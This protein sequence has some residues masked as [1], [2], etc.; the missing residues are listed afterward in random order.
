MRWR[1]AVALKR[2]AFDLRDQIKAR[3]ALRSSRAPRVSKSCAA[4]FWRIALGAALVAGAAWYWQSGHERGAEFLWAEPMDAA[5]DSSGFG[6][7]SAID[8]DATGRGYLLSDRGTLF[9]A[10]FGERGALQIDGARV[11]SD[12]QGKA[13]PR[14]KLDSEG[15]AILPDGRLAVSFEWRH[16]IEIFDVD[17]RSSAML[18]VP[19]AFAD[20]GSNAGLET[21]AVDGAGRLLAIP[22]RSGASSRPFPVFVHDGTWR[23]TSLPRRGAFL[24]VGADFGPQGRLY[25]LERDYLLSGF[26]SRIRRF[27]WDGRALSREEEIL[28]T[29]FWRHGNLEG[30]AVTKRGEDTMIDMVSDDNFLPVQRG[31][32]VRYRLK[33]P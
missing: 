10:R 1:F 31:A 30:I 2:L 28:R 27:D 13:L 24:P 3:R 12:A 21:L 22:E 33:T 14:P 18:P 7:I 19:E 11:L 25:L 8:L 9:D 15:L 32:L 23:E 6:G 16:R 26:R 29:R 17:G 5:G 4:G 20:L